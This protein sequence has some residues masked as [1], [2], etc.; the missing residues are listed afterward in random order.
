[1]E[2]KEL[3]KPRE[4]LQHALTVV[5][6]GNKYVVKLPTNGHLIDIEATKA[7][8]S[9][10]Q[11]YK[12]LEGGDQAMQAFLLTEAIATVSVLI[13]EVRESNKG[14]LVNLTPIESREIVQVYMKQ[15]APWLNRIQEEA[16]RPLEDAAK[17]E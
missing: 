1:M 7:R 8:L 13:P 11:H 6:Y 17:A 15:L 4:P 12:M 16:N 10:G 9:G 2:E 5:L 14:P 3:A